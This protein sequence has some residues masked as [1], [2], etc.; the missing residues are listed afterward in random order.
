MHPSRSALLVAALLGSAGCDFEFLGPAP[1]DRAVVRMEVTGGVA[2]VEYAYQVD[3]EGE[4]TGAACVS[5]CAFSAGDTLQHL[6][7]AQRV[8]FL[9]AVHRSGLPTAGRP[10]DYETECCDRFTYRVIYT[11]GREVRS[12][13][14]GIENFPAPLQRLVETLLRLYQGV[15][16]VVLRQ[17]TGLQGFAGHDLALDTVWVEDGVLA[18]AV[19]YGGGCDEHD[20]DAVAWTGWME[21]APVRLGV[22]LAHDHRGDT[23]KALIARTLRFDLTPVAVAYAEA[24]G[25]GASTVLLRIQAGGTGPVHEVAYSFDWPP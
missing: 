1:S 23:C 14:G 2:G 12:F 8:A 9:E 25:H 18:A 7:P 21:S 15:P 10:V 13:S 17:A 4:V 20:L 3:S 19:R 11:S 6:T 5:G 16:P 24:Y 22:A